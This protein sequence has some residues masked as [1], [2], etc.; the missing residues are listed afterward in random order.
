MRAVP[1]ELRDEG[2]EPTQRGH[3]RRTCGRPLAALAAL[4]DPHRARRGTHASSV[5]PRGAFLEVAPPLRPLPPL[6]SPR[7]AVPSRN[8][9]AEAGRKRPRSRSPSPRRPEGGPF[10]ETRRRDSAAAGSAAQKRERYAAPRCGP[11]RPPRVTFPP[12]PRAAAAP[13][14]CSL[15][16]ARPPPPPPPAAPSPGCPGMAQRTRQPGAAR[17]NGAEERPQC[18]RSREKSRRFCTRRPLLPAARSP[19]ARR[20]PFYHRRFDQLHRPAPPLPL[21][22]PPPPPAQARSGPAG[23]AY[24]RPRCGERNAELGSARPRPCRQRYG[25]SGDYNSSRAP[26]PELPAQGANGSVPRVPARPD[27]ISHAALRLKAPRR[28]SDRAAG[29][30][31]GRCGPGEAVGAGDAALSLHAA[32]ASRP[33]P[34]PLRPSLPQVSA[35][36]GRAAASFPF[37]FMAASPVPRGVGRGLAAPGPSSPLPSSSA[38][39][40]S[41]LR[42]MRARGLGVRGRAGPGG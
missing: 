38:R 8:A 7:G 30:R 26:R 29:R 31:G 16:A 19:R 32:V 24:Q 4:R 37:P 34:A 14:G 10:P 40:R 28:R 33:L 21:P 11:E 22:P 15:L 5:G 39:P 17:G 20:L 3:S 27:Y 25:R 2:P 35:V 23:A 13:D 9:A 36:G 41:A 6:S 42:W 12:P 18:A 1:P